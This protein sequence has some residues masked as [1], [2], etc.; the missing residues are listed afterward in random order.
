MIFLNEE[1]LKIWIKEESGNGKKR[2]YKTI[3]KEL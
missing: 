1:V 2:V 3:K